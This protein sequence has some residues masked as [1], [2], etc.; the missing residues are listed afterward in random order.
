MNYDRLLS[1]SSALAHNLKKY[2]KKCALSQQQVADAI[3]VERSSYTCYEIG[4]SIP[5][6]PTV[7]KIAKVFGVTLDELV[8]SEDN[9]AVNN[10][11]DT[12]SDYYAGD[13]TLPVVNFQNLTQTERELVIN[14]RLLKYEDMDYYLT[15]IIET[16]QGPKKKQDKE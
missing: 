13:T 7:I 12:N 6:I 11:A 14:F 8:M 2:R 4:K 3:K 15:K 9:P 10:V 16:V 5:T 1:D